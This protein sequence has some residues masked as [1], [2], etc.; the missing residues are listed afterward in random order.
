MRT[1]VR[2]DDDL[3]RA[4]KRHAAETGRSLTDLIAD[5]L[6][7]TLARRAPRRRGEPVHLQTSPGGPRPGVDLDDSAGLLDAMERPDA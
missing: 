6:R 7:E 1:T 5:A 3:L 4:A 2:L